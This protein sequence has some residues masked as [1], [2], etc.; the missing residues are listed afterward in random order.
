MLS[1]LCEVASW[2]SG[3]PVKVGCVLATDDLCHTPLTLAAV[4]PGLSINEV[5]DPG[6]IVPLAA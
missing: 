5:E 3:L 6:A 2:S 4:N 1:H